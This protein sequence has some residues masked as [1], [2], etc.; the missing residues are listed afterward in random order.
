LQEQAP[1]R[2]KL[3]WLRAGVVSVE[4]KSWLET[5]AGEDQGEEHKRTADEVSKS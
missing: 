1:N 5:M 4:D 2:L 3:L